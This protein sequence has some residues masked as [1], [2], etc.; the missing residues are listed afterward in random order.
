MVVFFIVCCFS[1]CGWERSTRISS[2]FGVLSSIKETCSERE[3]M[4]I[5][6][7]CDMA[8]FVLCLLLPEL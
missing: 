8:V 4:M 1:Y 3:S 6:F 7:N 2:C 5:D